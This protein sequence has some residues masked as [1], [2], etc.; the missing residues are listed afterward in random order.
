MNRVF[1]ST[2]A[3]LVLAGQALAAPGHDHAGD[4]ED[5]A[6]RLH[7]LLLQLDRQWTAAGRESDPV[8]RDAALAEHARLLVAARNALREM[9]EKSPCILLEARDAARQLACLTD[10]EARLQGTDKLLGHVINRL[11][12]PGG[13]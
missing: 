10:T 11:A 6:M 7:G 12:L 13:R 9:S 1:F 5:R 3:F 2:M 4:S 8:R